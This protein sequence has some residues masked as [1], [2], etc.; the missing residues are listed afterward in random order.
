MAYKLTHPD[1]DAEIE[2]RA[3]DVATYESQGW[4][5]APTVKSPTEADEKKK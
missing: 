1:S 3:E 5:T 2:V 4:E